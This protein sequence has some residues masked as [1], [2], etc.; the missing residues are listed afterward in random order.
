MNALNQHFLFR[1]L[2]HKEGTRRKS[3][4][5]YLP[6]PLLTPIT[7][8]HLQTTTVGLCSLSVSKWIDIS[9]SS[10]WVLR[11]MLSGLSG[12]AS[13][14]ITQVLYFPHLGSSVVSQ[15]PV[16]PL[17]GTSTP[18]CHLTDGEALLLNWDA[19]HECARALISI[20]AENSLFFISI[21][22]SCDLWSLGVIIYVMLCGYPPFYSKHHSRTIPKDMRKKI[23]T[24]SFDFPEDE[25]SQISEMA[26]DVVRKWDL[27]C[28][29]VAPC[30]CS[31][32]ISIVSTPS[33]PPPL[34]SGS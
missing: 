16:H 10:A 9:P 2:R 26:K 28:F 8:W 33:C 1:Y 13:Y 12:Y 32:W 14:Y 5:L 24:G 17:T 27:F 25:W 23:M 30:W 15:E 3:L 18:E 31:C 29:P 11:F 22:Q 34:P 7:R 20:S 6:H 19:S 21:F 4:E